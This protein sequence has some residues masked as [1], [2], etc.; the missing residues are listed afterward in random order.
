MKKVK[1][2]SGRLQLNKERVAALSQKGMKNLNGGGNDANPNNPTAQLT[3]DG[4]IHTIGHDD[5]S[6]CLSASDWGWCWC[7]GR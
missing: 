4:D 7:R 5:G 3:K 1:L 6:G 2:N